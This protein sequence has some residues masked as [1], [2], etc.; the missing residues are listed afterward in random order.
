MTE[1]R[2]RISDLPDEILH[3]IFSLV[4]VKS[5]AKNS[6]LSRTWS[7]LW[8][9][10]PVLDF[11]QVCPPM[12]KRLDHAN[13]LQVVLD[14]QMEA[15]AFIP[16]VLFSRPENSNINVFRFSGRLMSLSCLEDCICRVVNHR[17]GELQ[18]NLLMACGERFD[19]PHCVYE[20]DS[21]RSLTLI[22]ATRIRLRSQPEDSKPRFCFSFSL[23]KATSGLCSLQ[24]L[25]L[26]C[27]DI[28]DD[29]LTTDLF[30]DSS[31][32][33]LQNLIMKTCQGMTH[34]KISCSKLKDV[35][36]VDMNLNSLDISGSRLE[37][38]TNFPRLNAFYM[39][40]WLEDDVSNVIIKNVVKLLS[41]SSQI[42]VLDI[43]S[44]GLLLLIKGVM[45]GKYFCVFST[46]YIPSI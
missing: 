3:E 14:E 18:L 8:A 7:R 21:L 23:V 45:I 30:S 10:L 43:Q 9:T 15:L 25:T 28:L 34:L 16:R 29:H 37:N 12:P 20:C 6:A 32:P 41:A 46:A 31:F 33:F 17:V 38:L 26:K 2:D 40:Y 5:V 13:E 42:S 39:H 36:V 35:R 27:V 1:A 22:N 44:F 19:L 4:P 11:N 24:A